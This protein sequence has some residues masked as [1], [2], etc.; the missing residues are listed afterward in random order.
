MIRR[1]VLL[2]SSIGRLGMHKVHCLYIALSIL[3]R[4]T[5]T[6][7]ESIF[8]SEVRRNLYLRILALS[9]FQSRVA[10]ACLFTGKQR[11]TYFGQ[12]SRY[13]LKEQVSFGSIT[14]V[15]KFRG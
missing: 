7:V 12:F 8:R 9:T 4:R 5:G 14:G 10:S 15:R 6:D 1:K 2:K 3:R 11:S 13:K